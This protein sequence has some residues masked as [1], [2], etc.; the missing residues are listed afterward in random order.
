MQQIP[1]PGAIQSGELNII[2]QKGPSVPRDLFKL[3]TL[4]CF[5]GSCG[6]GKTYSTVELV[7]RYLELGCLNEIFLITSSW[8]NNENTFTPLKIKKENLFEAK[9]PDM[10]VQKILE[11]ISD[12]VEALADKYFAYIEYTKIFRKYQRGLKKK[13]SLVYLTLSER[14]IL[15]N[16]NYQPMKKVEK[17][18]CCLIIDDMSHT[19]IYS[20]SINNPMMNMAMRHRHFHKVGLTIIF[21]TQ[22]FRTGLPKCLRELA[23]QFCLYRTYDERQQD[24]IYE[25]VG[26]LCKKEEFLKML[27]EATKEKHGFL[28]ID[29]Q[30][31]IEGVHFRKNFNTILQCSNSNKEEEEEK[32]RPK[33]KKKKK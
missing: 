28:T 18:S 1:I 5:V 17:P 24:S 2:D 23:S 32:E 25:E 13:D 33:K 4:A 8:E 27:A 11:T 14:N 6:S 30:P 31:L 7:H 3:H 21:I 29:K 26:S 15:Y 12:M 22:N 16:N 10:N 9:P 20:S 19:P